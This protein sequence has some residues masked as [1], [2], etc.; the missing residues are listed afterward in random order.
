M[1][2]TAVLLVAALMLIAAL[3]VALE[4]GVLQRRRTA[5]VHAAVRRIGEAGPRD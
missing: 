1:V 3:V 4:D 2:E 5:R